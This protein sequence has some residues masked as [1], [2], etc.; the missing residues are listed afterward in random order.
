MLD[1]VYADFKTNNLLLVEDAVQVNR[2]ESNKKEKKETKKPTSQ[3]TYELWVE[4]NTIE[5]I[6]E[7]RK[8]TVGTIFGHFTKL[9]Q[10]KAVTI[11]EIMPIEKIEALSKVFTSYTE[12]SLN[13]LKDQV[14][15]AFT[16]DELKIYK[17]SLNS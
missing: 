16:W 13:P 5:Q 3:I 15:D 9:V 7:I 4:K 12:E 10:D 1:K 6:A 11:N 17:A 14:G 8:L 2:Y